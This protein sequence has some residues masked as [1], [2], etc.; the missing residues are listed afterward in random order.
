M[1][2]AVCT[3]CG[4]SKKPNKDG[5]GCVL[6]SVGD[7]KSCVM[8][9]ICGECNSGFSID[10]GKCVS[11]GSNRSGLSTGAIAGISVAGLVGLLC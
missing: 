7:C 4:E 9:N 6:C 2:A 3:S 11:S 10:N 5:T 1:T 8:D